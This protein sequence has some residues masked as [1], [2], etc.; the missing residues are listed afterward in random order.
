MGHI[1]EKGFERTEARRTRVGQMLVS[2][3]SK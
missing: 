3:N 2:E 1:R